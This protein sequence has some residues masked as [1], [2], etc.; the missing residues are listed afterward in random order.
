MNEIH[1]ATPP[2]PPEPPFVR[3][4]RSI[5][6][7]FAKLEELALAMLLL[8][9]IV[10][11]VYQAYKRNIAPP[12]PYWPDELIRYSVFYIGLIGAALASQ[13]DRLI[14]IDMFSRRFS[15]RG[16]LVVGLVTTA[17]TLGICVLIIM[18]G[19][20][21]HGVN[22]RLGE[23]GEVIAPATGILALP[24]GVGLIGFHLTLHAIIDIY[25]LATGRTPPAHAPVVI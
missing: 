17:F 13:S 16:R 24:I 21:V 14:N 10:L 19:L 6:K 1:D 23:E 12:S 3:A 5:D 4:L 15:P 9:L 11:A 7:A 25:Y 18:G 2:A 8:V 22:V 20:H